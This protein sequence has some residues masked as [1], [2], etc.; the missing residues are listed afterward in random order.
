MAKT[1]INQRL[2]E[3]DKRKNDFEA[4]KEIMDYYIPAYHTSSSWVEDYNNMLSNYRLFNNQINADTFEKICNPLGIDNG[5]YSENILPFNKIPTKINLLLGEELGRNESFS[6]ALLDESAVESKDLELK[7]LYFNY[8]YNKM[9]V[10]MAKMQMRMQGADEETIKVKAEQLQQNYKPEDIASFKSEYEM[11]AN[12]ILKYTKHVNNFKEKKNDGFKNMLISGR[13]PIRIGFIN[14]KMD[15]Q[16]VNPIHF[17]SIKGP[18]VS[19][20]EDGDAAGERKVYTISQVIREFGNSLSDE[21][22]N[23]LESWSTGDKRHLPK[24][25]MDYHRE[26]SMGMKYAMYFQDEYV[27]DFIGLHGSGRT[28]GFFQEELIWVSHVSW[29]WERKVGFLTE[30]NEFNEESCYIVD[31]SYELPDEHETVFYINDWG[32][33]NKKYVWYEEILLDTPMG[34][35]PTPLKREIE[36]LWIP[37]VWEGTR[38]GDD[39]YV[40]IREVPYSPLSISDPWKAKLPYH[41]TDIDAANAKAISPLSRAFPFAILYMI[42]MHM[43]VK[44]IARN[45]GSTIKI[46]TSQ[47]DPILGHGDINLALE[48]TL[49]LIREGVL[50]YNSY[51]DAE[52]SAMVANTARP[53]LDVINQSNTTDIINMTNILNWLDLQIGMS[54]GISPQRES[55]FSSNTNVSDNQQ[56]IVQSANI[57]QILFYKH[58]EIWRRVIEYYINSFKLYAKEM[59]ERHPNKDTLKLHYVLPNGSSSILELSQDIASMSDIGLYITNYGNASQYIN[60]MEELAL[61]FL[62]NDRADLGDI[63]MLIKSKIDGSSPEEIHDSIVKMEKKK[64]AQIQQQQEQ[65]SKMAQSQQEQQ[66]ELSFKLEELRFENKIKEIITEAEQERITQ[67]Q[68]IQMKNNESSN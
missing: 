43:F 42:V 23:K 59:F 56:A 41:G 20:Y 12:S 53:A 63:S 25:K 60:K 32:V 11:L 16:V 7:E 21:D 50:V 8:V 5:F 30:F 13:E 24:K 17:F 55:Q 64:Q 27:D 18:E 54:F 57:T 22:L 48:K 65:Q 66:V 10:E 38:I 6:V 45:Y 49:A 3:K 33:K 39:I 2:S 35:M 14:G 34:P 44:L 19:H 29:K 40:D 47:I 36:W 67:A 31:D 62:Q 4:A 46:D 15:Y 28:N 9:E 26:E 51:K 37:R 58:N 52:T 68:E 61:T 1:I